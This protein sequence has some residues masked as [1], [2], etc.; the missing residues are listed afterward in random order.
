MLSNV[1]HESLSIRLEH[2]WEQ[3]DIKL[4]SVRK[5]LSITLKALAA[6]EGGTSGTA[7]RYNS[8]NHDNLLINLGFPLIRSLKCP[9]QAGEW[10]YQALSDLGMGTTTLLI[11]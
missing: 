10:D 6:S 3:G 7:S 9:L 8:R 2:L 11:W 4:K 5:L 1:L